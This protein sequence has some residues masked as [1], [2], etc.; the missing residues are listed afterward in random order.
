MSA[1]LLSSPSMSEAFGAWCNLKWQYGA[2][3]FEHLKLSK[4]LGMPDLLKDLYVRLSMTDA[5]LECHR[6]KQFLKSE[7]LTIAFNKLFDK[8][9]LMM[10][11]IELLKERADSSRHASTSRSGD[12]DEGTD[13]DEDRC[14]VFKNVAAGDVEKAKRGD[15]TWL[16]GP[17]EAGLLSFVRVLSAAG[18]SSSLVVQVAEGKREKLRK[19]AKAWKSKQGV[20]MVPYLSR[21]SM[22]LRQERTAIYKGLAEA[23]AEPKW[24]GLADIEYLNGEGD[25]VLYVF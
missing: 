20:V 17:P 11:E 5:A 8:V 19:V 9:E 13:E 15:F 12:E 2:E 6:D 7:E 16:P 21:R 1:P 23:G 4:F 18:G 10:E 22:Q 3:E 25:R 24:A 14:V